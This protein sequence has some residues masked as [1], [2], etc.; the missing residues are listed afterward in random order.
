M[1][2]TAFVQSIVRSHGLD[3]TGFDATILDDGTVAVTSP[4]GLALYP[5]DGWT[6][7]FARHLDQGYFDVPLASVDTSG[8][9]ALMPGDARP[10]PRPPRRLP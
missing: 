2:H 4:T 8:N 10:Y 9:R 1:A 3:A 7:K 5:V 6:T